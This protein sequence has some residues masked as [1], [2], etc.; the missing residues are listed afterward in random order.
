CGLTTLEPWSIGWIVLSAPASRFWKCTARGFNEPG[1]FI[2]PGQLPAS[3][4]E[5]F[6]FSKSLSAAPNFSRRCGHG[7]RY[8]RDRRAV[9]RMS[10][11]LLRCFDRRRGPCR[12]FLCVGTP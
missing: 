9:Q 4:P 6:S 11:A 12:I 8:I 5:L 2:L 7:R 1:G 10:H 3:E